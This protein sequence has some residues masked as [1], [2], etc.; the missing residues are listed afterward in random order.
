M[1]DLELWNNNNYSGGS[2]SYNG[3]QGQDNIDANNDSLKTGDAWVIVFDQ[4]S[5]NGNLWMI[6]PNTPE[7]DL[8]HVE[9]VN[10]SGGNEGV[11]KNAIQSFIIYKQ[12]PSFWTTTSWPSRSQL[13]DLNLNQVLFGEN[14]D[15]LGDS[16]VFTGPY[17][18][19]SLSDIGWPDSDKMSGT[20]S[21]SSLKTGPNAWLIIFDQ[22]DFEGNFSKIAPYVPYSDLNEVGRFNLDGTEVGDWNDQ[23]QS[24][25]LYTYEPEFWNTS[26]SRPYVDFSTFYN[27][28]PYP[29]SSE[30]DNK[31]VYMVEDSTYTIDCPEFTEQSAKQSLSSYD[32]DNTTNLPT[33]GWTKY[34]MSLKHQNPAF[35]FDDTCNFDAYFDNTGSL[36]SIQHYDMNLNGAYQISDAVIDAVDFE[37]WMLGT[38]GAIESFGVSEEAAEAFVE[39]FDFVTAAFNK[40]SAAIYKITDNGGQFYFLPVVCHTINRL[41]TTVAKP[42]NT[43]IYSN[44][45]DPRENYTMAFD[46]GSFPGSLNSR[47][48]NG[49]VQNWQQENSLDGGTYPFDQASEYFYESCPFRTWY[50]ES[51]VSAQLGIFVSCKIDYEI[52]DNSKDD[53]IILLM[54]F[55]I[56]ATAGEKPTLTFAQATVQ[57]TDGS[58]ANII[59]PPYNNVADTSSEYY[60]TDIINAI[61]EYLCGQ[62]SGVSM[63]SDQHGRQYIDAVTQ[64]NM[65]AICDCVSFS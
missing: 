29:S 6:P 33:N 3:A 64:A 57:F 8:N 53:H 60:T 50:Q 4:T 45:G 52:G 38:T 12:E 27:L 56:P 9:R 49:S 46:N 44:S 2:D 43:T 59:T 16:G 22:T 30:S 21:V 7:S 15:Y 42:F 37:A 36:V 51:S 28:Y 10:Q 26:Y 65:Q 24:F 11:W 32:D 35:S 20:G 48:G 31:V 41:C 39:V 62:L 19:G 61:Y 13:T 47:I 55:Q 17:N 63:S 34:S 25:L 5:Y 54:G 40:F 1:A 58:N 14:S 23:I 18:A